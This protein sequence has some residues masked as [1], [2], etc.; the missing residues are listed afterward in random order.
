MSKIFLKIIGYAI[1]PGAL[2]I[3]LK[4]ISIFFLIS[5]FS[6][7][8]SLNSAQGSIFSTQILLNT[9]NDALF[10]N[11]V[12][13][14]IVFSVIGS[15]TLYIILKQSIF[16]SAKENPR[17]V[18]KLSKLNLLSWITKDKTDLLKIVIWVM[19]TWIVSG[20]LIS[21]SVMYSTYAWIGIL[22]GS[23]ALLITLLMFNVYAK[24]AE[25]L[26]PENKS[27]Y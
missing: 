12:S 24:E 6:L 3:T 8:F 21:Q 20:I 1:L 7:D 19:F 27:L 22:S 9:K 25:R 23:I 13:N 10:L 15:Y 2:I 14:L 17:T 26:Y 11:S 18:V 16:K 4:F 5:F